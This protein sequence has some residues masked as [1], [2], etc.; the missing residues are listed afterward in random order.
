MELSTGNSLN[1]LTN[2]NNIIV[3]GNQTVTDGR[4]VART[5]VLATLFLCIIFLTVAGN[6]LVIL[7]V[8]TEPMLRVV[9][10][11]YIVSLAVSDLL[12]GLLVLPFSATYQTLGHWV[13]GRAV[14]FLWCALDVLCCT[15]SICNLMVISIDR[16]LSKIIVASFKQIIL[17]VKTIQQS[18]IFN[19]GINFQFVVC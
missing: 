10:N 17:K 12:V 14:C 1:E 6:C 8:Y 19:N 4:S 15:A 2:G 16:Y 5:A 11:Y 7:A 3:D 13:F 18:I 9:T